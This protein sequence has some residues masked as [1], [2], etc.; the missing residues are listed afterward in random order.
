MTCT[1]C[2]R[3]EFTVAQPLALAVVGPD[4]VNTTERGMKFVPVVCDHRG[5]TLLINAETAGL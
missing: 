3:D 5:N 1:L 4:G 2:K